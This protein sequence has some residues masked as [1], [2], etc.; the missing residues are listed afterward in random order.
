MMSGES[1]Q[2]RRILQA[3]SGAPILALSQTFTLA[4]FPGKERG[5]ALAVWSIALTGGWVFAPVFGAYVAD[6]QSWRLVFFVLAPL[7]VAA[8][9][10]CVTFIPETDKDT[11]LKFDWFGFIALSIALAGLQ[12]VLNRG[13][14]LD[15]FDSPLDYLRRR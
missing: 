2:S 9:V 5:M 7:G 10:L 15:W 14:R 11:E 4:A 6:Q 12:I 1:N 8:T 3:V 13:Q